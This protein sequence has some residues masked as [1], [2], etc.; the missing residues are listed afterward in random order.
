M[1]LDGKRVLLTGG[2]KGIGRGMA[3]AFAAAGAQVVTCYHADA[4]AADALATEL[5][6]LGGDH[7]VV[8]ADVSREEEVEALVATA[9]ERVGGLDTLV[10]NAGT[11]SHVPFGDLPLAEW[12]RVLDTNLTSAYLLVHHALPMLQPGASVTLVGSRSAMVGIPL[13]S[14]YTAGKAGLVGLCRSLAKE[15]GPRGVRVNVL[16]PGVIAPDD[17]ELPEEMIQRYRQLTALGRLG[18]TA[19]VAG[20]ALF[21]ASD[22][23]AYVTGETLHVDGGI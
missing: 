5:K 12:K 13:R 20:A 2:T 23:A 7:H 14:H 1:R 11:I 19:E 16:A 9:R 10:S 3:L 6:Q 21:L 22:L 15:L 4:D 17:A 8:Q 18:R